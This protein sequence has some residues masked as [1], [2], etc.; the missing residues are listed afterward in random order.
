MT[1]REKRKSENKESKSEPPVATSELIQPPEPEAPKPVEVPRPE[2]SA[3]RDEPTI[4][5]TELIIDLSSSPI[6][7][8]LLL[9][10]TSP[11][12]AKFST[13][14]SLSDPPLFV[15]HLNG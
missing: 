1:F 10:Q 12:A 4:P 2:S 11:M 9:K 8:K 15:G 7:D 13:S 6:D 5:T 14:K 3:K